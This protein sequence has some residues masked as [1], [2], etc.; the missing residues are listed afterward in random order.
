[1]NISHYLTLNQAAKVVGRSKGTISKALKEGKLSYLSKDDSG[2]KID[3]SELHRV[4]PLNTIESSNQVQLETPKNG[5]ENTYRTRE[6]ELELKHA[7]ELLEMERS[8]HAETK[9]EKL[10]LL[11]MLE[12]QTRLLTHIREE[13][14][15]V[16]QKPVER[17][18]GFWAALLGKN[19]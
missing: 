19:T 5:N 18:G 4:F 16:T 8:T 9:T 11:E 2:Y 17:K 1:M 12:N 14:D 13:A 3:P 6:L 10:R 15:K 7:L